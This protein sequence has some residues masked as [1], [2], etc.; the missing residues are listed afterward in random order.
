M[1]D[2]PA[3]APDRAGSAGRRAPALL[4]GLLTVGLLTVGLLLLQAPLA[5]RAH[6]GMIGSVPAADADVTTAPSAV[7]LEF[8]A[9]PVAL[10]TEVLVTGP[11]GAEVSQGPADLRGTTVVQPLAGSLA[12][13]GYTVRWRSSSA[14]GHPVAGS[15]SF[16]V[17][18]EP[19]G[20]AAAVEDVPVEP[21]VAAQVTDGRPPVGWLT[22]GLLGLGATGLL[23]RRRLRGR[24]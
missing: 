16:T 6:D 14:D 18:G 4:T 7:Q 21:V 12:D 19:G 23:L 13:G 3:V 2:S 1:T 11:D 5:A 10:G 9:P 17:G 20:S 8:S 15:W 24:A 22:V